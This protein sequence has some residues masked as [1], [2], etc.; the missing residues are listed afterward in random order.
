MFSYVYMYVC[1]RHISFVDLGSVRVS[2]LLKFNRSQ[3]QMFLKLALV[4][5]PL[6]FKRLEFYKI[7]F[8]FIYQKT[9]MTVVLFKM[10]F[11]WKFFLIMQRF[12]C[13]IFTWY[14]NIYRLHQIHLFIFLNILVGY[15]ILRLGLFAI[16]QDR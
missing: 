10:Q 3:K 4:E 14:L 12:K 1:W 8:C 9:Y 6:M 16:T 2:L 11:S 5:S 7:G 13:I 15:K